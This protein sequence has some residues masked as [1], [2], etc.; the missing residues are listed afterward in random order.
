MAVNTFLKIAETCKE[1]FVIVQTK[2]NEFQQ[3]Q[4]ENAPYIEELIR[5]IPDE[6]NLLENEHKFVFYEAVGHLVSAEPNFD[7]KQS[8]LQGVLQDYWQFWDSMLREIDMNFESLRVP[9]LLLK[10]LNF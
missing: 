4:I 8:L 1:E 10:S 2:Q 5:S 6:T 9:F 7:R 3:N